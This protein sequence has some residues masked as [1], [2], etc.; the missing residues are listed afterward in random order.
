MGNHI[1]NRIW[2]D[3]GVSI[4]KELTLVDPIASG[5]S[6]MESL[7]LDHKGRLVLE[8]LCLRGVPMVAGQV[9]KV[10]LVIDE[11]LVAREAVTLPA[12]DGPSR[13]RACGISG[14]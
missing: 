13:D 12:L 5:S 2:E 1:R 14:G 11:R 6:V 4:R 3:C 10:L 7:E 9:L 8:V